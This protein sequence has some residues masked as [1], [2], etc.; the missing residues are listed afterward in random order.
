MRIL[1]A[2]DAATTAAVR[3]CLL[4]GGVVAAPTETVYGLMARWDAP[5]ARERIYRM[6]QRPADKSLQMLVHCLDCAAEAGL[7]PDD[8]LKRL[9]TAFWPGPLTVV[10]NA[11]EGNTLGVRIPDHPFLLGVLAALRLPLAA[12]SANRSGRPPALDAA[13]AVQDLA[14]LPDLLVD[15]G[16]IRSGRALASSVVDITGRELRIV[17]PGPIAE[18]AIR[19]AIRAE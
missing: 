8:R 14:E 5:E 3:D 12:T 6:K 9:A 11:R 17:R 18:E 13:T 1:T 10:C 15:G 4:G 7:L 19:T 16:P 2:M